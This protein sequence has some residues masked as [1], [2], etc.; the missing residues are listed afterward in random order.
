MKSVR[1]F[2]AGMGC[3]ILAATSLGGCVMTAAPG[4]YAS[5]V[6]TVAPPTPRVEVY[7]APPVTGYVWLGGYW[8]WVG[9]RY[10]WHTGSW[11]PGRPGY[12]WVSHTWV[13]VGGGWRMTQEHWAR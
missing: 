13:R 12:H 3:L 9:G 6:V 2:K 5:A 4:H 10:V 7:G 8:D 11:G 1:G